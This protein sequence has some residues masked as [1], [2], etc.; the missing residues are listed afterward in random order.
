M[1]TIANHDLLTLG[2][3]GFDRKF[4]FKKPPGLPWHRAGAIQGVAGVTSMAGEGQ[5]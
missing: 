3:R 5:P 4:R 2:I 1:K